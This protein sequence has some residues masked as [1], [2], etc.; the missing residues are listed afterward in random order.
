MTS[1]VRMISLAVAAAFVVTGAA[2]FLPVNT[3]LGIEDAQA[4][5][6]ARSRRPKSESKDK[7]AT[8]S[9]P[10]MGE[11]AFKKIDAARECLDLEDFQCTINLMSQFLA[12]TRWSS[13]ERATANQMIAYAYATMAGKEKE[14]ARSNPLYRQA[15]VYFKDAIATG[16]FT[17]PVMIGTVLNLGQMYMVLEDWDNAAYQIELWFEMN[18]ADEKWIPSPQP[19]MMLAQIYYSQGRKADTIPLVEEAIRLKPTPQKSWY[20]FLVALH[21][22]DLDYT[23]AMPILEKMTLVFPNDKITYQQLAAIYAEK[24]MDTKSLAIHEILH[25]RGFIEKESE[26]RQ[27]AQL[28][29][30]HE[31]PYKAASAMAG[32]IENEIA[33]P[34]EENL[35]MVGD[36]W[37]RAREYAKSIDPLTKAAG[38]SDTG[39]IY[40]RL[41][42]SYFETEEWD[43]AVDAIESAIDK[44]G[45]KDADEGN[46]Y[47]LTGIASYYQ[48]D[49]RA[50]LRAFGKARD[51]KATTKNAQRWVNYLNAVA[52]LN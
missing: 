20:Q 43:K 41:G 3:G 25:A 24:G 46:A 36:N 17:R 48:D 6:A 2:E 4:Q 9:A 47:Y 32:C 19:Y 10:T 15:I 16:G 1:I 12:S 23:S 18:E 40:L 51:Y 21:L 42:R 30:F 13:H 34:D 44:G 26:C 35:E 50:A 14:M 29:A 37:I 11:A 5:F 31:L 28:Y 52:Q 38:L 39:D 49:M 27:L 7:P 45:L 22:E 8:K 33:K